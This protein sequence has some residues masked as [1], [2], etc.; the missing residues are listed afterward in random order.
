MSLTWIHIDTE[1]YIGVSFARTQT[2]VACMLYFLAYPLLY[3]HCLE[4]WVLSQCLLGKSRSPYAHLISA[5]AGI[6]NAFALE[7]SVPL[8]KYQHGP[9]LGKT[10]KSPFSCL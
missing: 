5:F 1:I 8:I 4:K 3:R 9:G 2:Q 10:L 7:P 6:S